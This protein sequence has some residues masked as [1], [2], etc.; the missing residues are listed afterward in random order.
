MTAAR[1]IAGPRTQLATVHVSMQTD[2]VALVD[3]AAGAAF[4][5]RT[6]I[7]RR[8]VLAGL[9]AQPEGW[10]DTGTGI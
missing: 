1:E 7:V 10:A 6:E 8:L 9:A 3:R 4:T 5:S 2:L